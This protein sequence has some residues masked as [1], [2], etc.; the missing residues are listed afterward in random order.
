MYHAKIVLVFLAVLVLTANVNAQNGTWSW[1]QSAGG[2]SDD[3][4]VDLA[5][6]SQGSLYVC[7]WFTGQA[8]FGS[9]T[10]TASGSMDVFVAKLS[11]DGTWLW[12][13]QAG[14]TQSCEATGIA[15]DANSEVYVCGNL[16]GT[17]N[18]GMY[19]LSTLGETD[20]FVTKL[21]TD[22]DWLWALRGGGNNM[23][24][25]RDLDVAPDGSI[26]LGGSFFGTATFGTNTFTSPNPTSDIFVAR[27]DPTGNWL[28]VK[29]AGG[30]NYD[31]CFGIAQS[32]PNVYITGSFFETAA[33]GDFNLT[34]L[35]NKDI[36]VA[37]L[38]ASTGNWLSAWQAG[39]SDANI[40]K[41]VALDSAGNAYLSGSGGGVLD[42]G[43]INVF[44]PGSYIAK[45]S[46]QGEWLWA[47]P[48][49]GGDAEKKSL[50]L[51]QYSNLVVAGSFS[52]VPYFGNVML[53]PH[54]GKDVFVAGLDPSGN[55]LWAKAAG[56]SGDD[57]ASGM[58]HAANGNTFISGTFNGSCEFDGITINSAGMKDAFVA[59]LSGASDVDDGIAPAF[60]EIRLGQNYPNPFAGSSQLQVCADKEV[61][62]C[63]L[64][65]YDIK[66][67]KL[68]TIFKGYLQKGQHSF[69]LDSYCQNLGTGVYLVSLKTGNQKQTRKLVK[70]P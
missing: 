57:L 49:P 32:G 67:R 29:Q 7:G 27:L 20:V 1:A 56:G 47:I 23:D 24:A 18:F 26:Y 8:T 55:W 51:D 48:V 16:N 54:A 69:S 4:G 13:K 66:G 31:D 22:G 43:S 3:R 68:H 34:S 12:V 33:F 5:M 17:S 2:S 41:S 62:D 35:G 53:I 36:Y 25:A 50:C 52:G 42:F 59:K 38:D 9:T 70:V 65:L 14:G 21:S 44:A 58:V 28:W 63:E 10:L 30:T 11:S 15:V 60:S 64:T 6:D 61:E 45:L 19:Q 37:K 39:S 40:G 46:P